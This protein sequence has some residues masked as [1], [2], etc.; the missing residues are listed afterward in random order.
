MN[1]PN[2]AYCVVWAVGEYFLTTVTFFLGINCSYGSHHHHLGTRQQQG[3]ETRLTRLEALLSSG[4][5]MVVVGAVRAINTYKK[6][7]GSQKI[8]T[9]SPNN[10]IRVVWAI[11]NIISTY[12]C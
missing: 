9:N 2:N 12:T 3:F 8:L 6:G 1:G 10:A 7:Y 4:A 5:K 11:Q